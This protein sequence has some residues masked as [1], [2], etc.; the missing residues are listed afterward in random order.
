[1]NVV[2]GNNMQNLNVLIVLT[3]FFVQ[4]FYNKVRH[5]IIELN[6]GVLQMEKSQ[7]VNYWDKRAG[8]FGENKQ[9][10]LESKHALTWINEINQIAPIYKDM[11]ILD[12]GTGAGFFSNLMYSAWR[13]SHWYRSF[14][15]DDRTC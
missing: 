7:I 13:G 15:R 2:I 1:M 6:K 10:E 5:F 8:S 4:I 3:H 9:A 14:T 11:K 12:I